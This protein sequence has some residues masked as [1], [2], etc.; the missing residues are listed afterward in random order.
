[1]TPLPEGHFYDLQSLPSW[2][3][4]ALAAKSLLVALEVDDPEDTLF[5]S[6]TI[7]E[8]SMLSFGLLVLSRIFPEFVHVASDLSQKVTEVSD[9]QNF[10]R[11]DTLDKE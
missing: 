8:L 1:M 5:V 3:Q 4:Y 7:S 6:L 10:L 11:K 9:A 2:S